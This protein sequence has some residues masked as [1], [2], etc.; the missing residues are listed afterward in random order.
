MYEFREINPTTE[1]FDLRDNVGE[2]ELQQFGLLLVAYNEGNKEGI[3][4]KYVS[5]L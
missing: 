2:I 5:A 1:R 4:V 3:A